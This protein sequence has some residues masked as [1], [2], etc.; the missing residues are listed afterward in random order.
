MKFYGELLVFVLLLITNLR[1]FFVSHVRRDPLVML[2]PFTFVVAI[3]Q[4]A[5]WGID[6]FTTLGLLIALFVLLSNFHALFRYIEYLYV[7]H[8][9]PLMKTWAVFTILIT[10]VAIA[11][12][13]FFKPVEIRNIDLGVK[14]T[15]TFYKGSFR[16]GFENAGP[17]NS[18]NLTI[19]KFEP[20]EEAGTEKT[21]SDDLVIL[22]MPDK[23]G[24]TEH[25]RPYLQRLAAKGAV[26]YSADFFS[27]DCKWLHSVADAKILRRLVMVTHS[28]LNNQWFMSQ[29]E[30]YTYNCSM[31]YEVLLGTLPP[32]K[33]FLVTDVMADTAASDLYKKN[34]EMIAG[35][36]A[37][38]SVSDYKTAG[39]GFVEQ[40]D[41]VLAMALG[42][43]TNRSSALPELTAEKTLDCLNLIT[44][45]VKND[46]E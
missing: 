39:Y 19:Y 6:I 45:E 14:E 20:D 29:R 8:Y 35:T 36:F 41:P 23:R 15:K 30:Y 42:L 16:S 31:E 7:D 26:V 34:P 38:D 21:I 9:S 43:S 28:Y 33:F 3:L 17:F 24:D 32:A 5:A 4:I 1:V 2:A 46:A 13:I 12:I 10:L 40:T 18:K 27:E 37:L 44:K 22:F 11:G 25:Y